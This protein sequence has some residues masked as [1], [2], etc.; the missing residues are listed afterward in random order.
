MNPTTAS[1]IALCLVVIAVGVILLAQNNGSGPS[2]GDARNETGNSKV[3]DRV[4]ET[5]Q[6]G[7]SKREPEER[8]MH[9]KIDR[10]KLT[11]FWA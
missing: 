3:S 11:A 4:A 8:K 6:T 7:E 2:P 5:G 10:D 1:I 9:L